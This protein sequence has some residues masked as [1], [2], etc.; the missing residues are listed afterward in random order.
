MRLQTSPTHWPRWAR[1]LVVAAVVVVAVV[2]VVRL[3]LDPVVTRLTRRG[4][5]RMQGLR[6]DFEGVHVTVFGPGYTI[7]RFKLVEDPGGDWRAPVFYA[8]T[9]HI[10]LEWRRL[11]H[12][13][14]VARAVIVEPKVT[15]LAGAGPA[16]PKRLK[17]PD[18]SAQLE[19]ITPFKIDRVEIRR[20]E[21]LFRDASQ[22]GHPELWVHR[23]E[24]VA[25]N[26]A[27][28]ESLAHDNPATIRA[29]GTVG[30]SGDLKLSVSAD[31]F[32]SPL[33]FEGRF[34]MVGLRVSELFAFVAPKTKLQTPKGTIDL[35]AKF[36]A[37][38]GRVTGGVK[39]VLANVEV[40]PAEPGVWDRFK[41]WLVGV[42]L[43]AAKDHVPERHAVVTIVPIEG[44][45]ASPDVQL[46]PA[47]LG[48]VRNA[49]VEGIASGFA[50]LPPPVAPEKQGVVEQAKNA[51]SKGHGP[52]AAQ[53]TG[54]PRSK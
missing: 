25:R 39:P 32:A 37:K 28:R 40:R 33:A 41:A 48:V 23:L 51:L 31:L 53:P 5:S 38:G 15:V 24:L 2:V 45:L 36:E 30:K 8:E 7:T 11:F 21:F 17:T 3:T 13:E 54:A 22:P 27:T 9:V 10:G 20:G 49:F 34:D 43:E 18:L 26:L 14:L 12:R 50:D 6:G 19:T 42:G 4:L 35:F 29:T 1:R 44:R 47:I 52:P 16:K 46:W